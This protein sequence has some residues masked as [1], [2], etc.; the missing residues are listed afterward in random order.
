MRCT[1]WYHMYNIKN[2]K[3]TDGGVLLLVT[4]FKL[5]KWSVIR[6]KGESQNGGNK[7]ANKKWT[8]VTTWY[9]QVRTCTCAYQGVRNV[10]F[11]ENLACFTFLLPLFWDS[12]F[13]LIT[14][15][16]P[17]HWLHAVFISQSLSFNRVPA[18]FYWF[19]VNSRNTT[20][21]CEICSKLT[22]KTPQRRHWLRTGV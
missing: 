20:K 7:K 11:S 8:F 22:I 14:D 9:A 5:Y 12:P 13:C 16:L 18:N 6:Q 2:A 21:R 15:E 4:F 1:I 17:H 10:R 19:K 3:N